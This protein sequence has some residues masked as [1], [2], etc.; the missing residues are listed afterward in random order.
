MLNA[1]E[2]LYV[3][4]QEISVDLLL[5]RQA[6]LPAKVDE[7]PCDFQDWE[8]TRILVEDFIPALLLFLA[9]RHRANAS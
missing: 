8:I 6:Q 1:S 9:D 2:S 7:L 5:V 4:Q 3:D